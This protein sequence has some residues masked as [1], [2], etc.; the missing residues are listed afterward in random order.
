MLVSIVRIIMKGLHFW[1]LLPGVMKAVML[2]LQQ[3]VDTDRL[4]VLIFVLL[5]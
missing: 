5:N 2:W 1:T 4:V 3:V